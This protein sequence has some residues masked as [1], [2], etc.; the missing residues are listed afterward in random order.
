MAIG[1]KES[2]EPIGMV[3]MLDIS[4]GHLKGPQGILIGRVWEQ[5]QHLGV[6]LQKDLGKGVRNPDFLRGWLLRNND[7]VVTENQ[8]LS[9][10]ELIKGVIKVIL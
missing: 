3:C 7:V 10:C 5:I 6:V 1:K 2:P 9:D 8:G 4:S